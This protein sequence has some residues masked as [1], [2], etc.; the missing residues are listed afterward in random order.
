M[1]Q[2]M[3]DPVDPPKS[4]YVLFTMHLRQQQKS[5]AVEKPTGPPGSFFTE[6]SKQWAALEPTAKKQFE[7]E[8]QA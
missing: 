1:A 7:D 8:A 5:G 2:Q 3:P 6:C 4:A